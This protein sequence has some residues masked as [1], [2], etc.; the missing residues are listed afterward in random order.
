[1]GSKVSNVSKIK[2]PQRTRVK[3]CGTTRLEDAQAAVCYGV[4]ALG[5]IFYAKSPRYISLEQAAEIIKQLPPLVDR[6]GVFV[7]ASI[8][9]VA[10]AAGAG[11]S[12]LQLHGNESP[13]YCRDIRKQLPFCGIIKAFRVGEESRPEDFT[14]Y[15]EC[16]DAFLLDTYV[17]GASGGTGKVFD[18]SIIESLKLK[19]PIFLAGGLSSGNVVNAI[20]E[21]RPFAVDI[22]SGVESQP[23]VKDHLRLGNLLQLV[24]QTSVE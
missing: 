3:M 22:N 24:Y 15:N 20:S 17:Q 6:V 1:M 2:M 16:V 18:W 7:N 11:L 8:E 13:E 4:D 9:E 23:G 5:F 12:Y 19:R 14:P 21:V 10:M